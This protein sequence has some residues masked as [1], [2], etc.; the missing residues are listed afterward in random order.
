MSGRRTG[1]V[2]FASDDRG[3]V[4]LAVALHSLLSAA[5]P[6]RTLRVSVLTGCGPL[7]NGHRARLF[8]DVARFPFASLEIL[9]AEALLKPHLASLSH[10]CS[11][12]SPL[13]WARCLAGELFPDEPGPVVYLDIDTLVCED[14]GALYDLDLSDCGDG[15]PFVLG[16]VAEAGRVSGNG[17]DPIWSSPL[18]DGRA[19]RY[20]NSGVL[21]MN[22]EAFRK[23]NLFTKVVAWHAAHGDAVIRPDQDALNCL[24]WDRVRYLHPRYNHC[25]G[26]L[27]RQRRE[28]SAAGEWRGNAPC[29]ILEAI[30]NPTILHFWGAKKPWRAN[31]RPEG[32]RYER[33][34]RAVGV[35][36][37]ALPGTTALHRLVRC[38]CRVWQDLLRRQVAARLRR[39]GGRAT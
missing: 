13:I 27:A 5:D 32:P 4:P 6:Q 33:T 14:L 30:L 26:W 8:E 21:V 19:T 7:S 31:R 17:H 35:L 12:W 15:R 2:V 34:M 39:P 29:E 11:H 16:A 28:S 37:G 22:V 20:F 36:T 25:D 24:F 9:D 1:H 23:E 18:F 3:F 38:A 10:A